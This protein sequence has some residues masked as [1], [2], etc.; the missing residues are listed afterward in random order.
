MNGS[1]VHLL[2][3]LALPALLATSA[4]SESDATGPEAAASQEVKVD[5]DNDREWSVNIF[6]ERDLL[7]VWQGGARAGQDTILDFPVET[8]EAGPLRF[9][10]FPQDPGPV[11]NVWSDTLELARGDVV[12]I[13]IGADIEDSSILIQSP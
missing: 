12:E 9:V 3:L 6:A 8:A 7:P 13:L 10:V 11:P 1:R 5:I 4:C 2:A